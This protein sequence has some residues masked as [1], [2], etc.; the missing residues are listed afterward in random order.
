TPATGYE[1]G[2]RHKNGQ[3]IMFKRTPGQASVQEK[4]FKIDPPMAAQTGLMRLTRGH[5][6]ALENGRN[7]RFKLVAPARQT[8]LD[9]RMRKSGNKPLDGQPAVELTVELDMFLA[10][11]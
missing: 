5:L 9:L 4:S 3:W 8:I 1:E 11:W 10:N 7:L 2:I 6:E